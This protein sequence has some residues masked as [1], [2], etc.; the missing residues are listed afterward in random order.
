LLVRDGRRTVCE[1]E[2]AEGFSAGA[3][4]FDSDITFGRHP[5]TAVGVGQVNILAVT[6]DGRSTDDAGLSL[7]ELADLLVELGAEAAINLDGGGSTSLVSGGRLCNRPRAQFGVEI[8][9]GR[10]IPTALVFEPKKPE[11]PVKGV[12]C[13]RGFPRVGSKVV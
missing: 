10:P 6:C 13:N 11:T 4:Q 8:P 3:D 2:D 1:G 7:V 12:L 5:R 9:G